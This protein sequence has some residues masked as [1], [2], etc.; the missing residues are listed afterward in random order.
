[1]ISLTTQKLSVVLDKER[2]SILPFL[3]E[4]HARGF[5]LAGG[6]ALALIFEHRES[7]DFDFFVGSNF[8]TEEL[9]S[10]CQKLFIGRKIEKILDS[11]NTLWITVDEVKLSFFTLEAPILQPFIKTQYFDIASIYDIGA[12]KL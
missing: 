8:S 5:Y 1:M 12:M 9:F 7:E 11:K 10:F 6:T 3:K 4:F 2:L